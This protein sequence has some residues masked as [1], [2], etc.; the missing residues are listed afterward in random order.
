M[1][2]D[3]ILG[4][5]ELQTPLFHSVT[6]SEAW[7]LRLCH[8]QVLAALRRGGLTPIPGLQLRGA[9]CLLVQ[10]I[11]SRLLFCEINLQIQWSANTLGW[12]GGGAGRIQTA[13]VSVCFFLTII[14][15]TSKFLRVKEKT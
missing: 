10:L 14:R 5:C 7:H 12:G 6:A 1:K 11:L 3:E 9:E 4:F 13:I 8:P 2:H 15:I